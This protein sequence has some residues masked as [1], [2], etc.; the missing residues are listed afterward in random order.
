METD[1]HPASEGKKR[2]GFPEIL[3]SMDRPQLSK[4][5][6]FFIRGNQSR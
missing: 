6:C 1:V 5:I 3:A 4:E 2:I